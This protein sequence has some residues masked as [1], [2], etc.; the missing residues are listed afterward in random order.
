MKNEV[1]LEKY[2][3]DGKCPQCGNTRKWCWTWACFSAE[4]YLLQ[5]HNIYPN[6]EDGPI[7]WNMLWAWQNFEFY[8]PTTWKEFEIALE[9]EDY[10]YA[11]KLV[12]RIAR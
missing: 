2:P 7:V 5:L 10:D 4:N 6:R 12:E 1:D 8:N 3:P 11:Q 9:Y